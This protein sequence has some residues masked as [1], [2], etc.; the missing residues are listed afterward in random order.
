MGKKD[1]SA[2]TEGVYD[3]FFSAPAEVKKEEPKKATT[4]PNTEKKKVETSKKEQTKPTTKKELKQETKKTPKK[5][6]VS[7]VKEKTEKKPE[8]EKKEETI[9]TPEVKIEKVEN[10]ENTKTTSKSYNKDC[11]H[12]FYLDIELADFVTNYL[13]LTRHRN[14][15][16]YFNQLIKQDLLKR[17]GLP[18]DT[19]NE[20]MLKKWEEYKKTIS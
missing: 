10:I 6:T 9:S 18:E 20:E 13:W 19:T 8:E 14:Y 17:L 2:I 1:F 4:K 11:R 16:Q 7:N 3:V 5:A 12:N 15:S